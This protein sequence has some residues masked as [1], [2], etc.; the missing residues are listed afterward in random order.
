MENNQKSSV[1]A[2]VQTDPLTTTIKQ[3]I[4][5]D[6]PKKEKKLQAKLVATSAQPGWFRP[7]TRSKTGTLNQ[8]KDSLKE[9][10]DDSSDASGDDEDFSSHDFKRRRMYSCEEYDDGTTGVSTCITVSQ[11]PNVFDKLSEFLKIENNLENFDLYAI[12]TL[13]LNC[14]MDLVHFKNE[15]QLF[16]FVKKIV[17]E[18]QEFKISGN[19]VWRNP[20]PQPTYD[21]EEDKEM[22]ERYD[23]LMNS[24]EQE[25]LRSYKSDSKFA[26]KFTSAEKKQ[27]EKG[28]KQGLTNREI[29]V[30]LGK[31]VHANHVTI[32]R[33]EYLRRE[34]KKRNEE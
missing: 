30:N 25:L 15:D 27:I 34:K 13:I 2:A 11:I 24:D 10:D 28:I 19:K 20:V 9:S 1:D 16:E 3:N 29:S 12:Q 22:I 26:K 18:R 4:V 33:S 8:S 21:E 14:A 7:I 32:Y 31:N 6:D 5:F 17:L 23:E